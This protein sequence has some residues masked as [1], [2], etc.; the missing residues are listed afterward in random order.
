M[1]TANKQTKQ[2][3][4]SLLQ[5]QHHLLFPSTC[6]SPGHQPPC[7]GGGLRERTGDMLSAAQPSGTAQLEA[8]AH[9]LAFSFKSHPSTSFFHTVRLLAP[10]STPSSLSSIG[11]LSSNKCF[12]S[13][14]DG[15]LGTAALVI[16]W[17]EHH[18]H[19]I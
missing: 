16:Y 13:H 3:A 10:T 17:I 5:L 4:C 8:Q 18:A 15:Y 11:R 19:F 2:K 14:I 6:Q 1:L 12:I 7:P 9:C